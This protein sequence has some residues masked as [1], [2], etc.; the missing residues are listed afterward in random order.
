MKHEERR[1][2]PSSSLDKAEDQEVAMC[3]N[4]FYPSH[5]RAVQTVAPRWLNVLNAA[6]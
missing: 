5:R 1:Q 2:L 3:Y 6:A 4:A